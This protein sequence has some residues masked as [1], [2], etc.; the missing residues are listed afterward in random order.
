MEEEAEMT[1]SRNLIHGAYKK[2]FFP[3]KICWELNIK[4]EAMILKVTIAS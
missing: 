1:V 3:A 4:K 2:W